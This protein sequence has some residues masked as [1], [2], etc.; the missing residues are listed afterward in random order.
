[1][2]SWTSSWQLPMWM[3]VLQSALLQVREGKRSGRCFS[4]SLDHLRCVAGVNPIPKSI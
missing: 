2:A 1:M 3:V 4:A